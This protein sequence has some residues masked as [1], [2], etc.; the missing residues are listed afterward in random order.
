[1]GGLTVRNDE[2]AVG[3]LQTLGVRLGVVQVTLDELDAEGSDGLG[4]IAV[5]V[6]GE[7][8]HLPLVGLLSQSTSNRGAL[9][10]CC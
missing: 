7:A 1:M 2:G 10:A 6:A 9:V 5:G 3:T 4:S 8:V